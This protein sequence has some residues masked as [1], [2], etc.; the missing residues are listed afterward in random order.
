MGGQGLTDLV[1]HGLAEARIELEFAVD[2]ARYRVA[3][4][5]SRRG[6]SSATFERADGED[7]LSDVEGSGVKVVTRRIEELLRLDFDAFTRAVVL[8]QGE[9]QRFLRG[10][11]DE[12]REVLTDLLGLHHYEVMGRRARARATELEVS[13]A[14]TQKILEE[15]YA[16]ATPERLDEAKTK[17]KAAAR[18]A[19]ALAKAVATATQLDAKVTSLR[20]GRQ[21]LELHKTGTE[22]IRSALEGNRDACRQAREREDELS[23][24]ARNAQ[25]GCNETKVQ[26]DAAQAALDR[27][28]KRYGSLEEL[29]RAEGSLQIVI[30]GQGDLAERERRLEKLASEL[31]TLKATVKAAQTKARE[32]QGLLEATKAR[33][34]E[35]EKG[36][37]DAN[38]AASE[39]VRRLGKAEE[40]SAELKE[41]VDETSS[42]AQRAKE[43]T[44]AKQEAQDAMRAEED[45]YRQLADQELASALAQHLR[46]GDPCP[47]CHRVLEAAP[48]VDAH[49]AEALAAG[50]ERRNRARKNL[51][52]ANE[53]YAKAQAA[54]TNAE[55][56][57]KRAQNALDGALDGTRNI[58]VL[59]SQA[60]RAQTL[61]ERR[62][63]ELTAARKKVEA[64]I[65]AESDA[66]VKAEN[67]VRTMADKTSADVEMTSDC[68]E[69][70]KRIESAAKTVRTQ[71]KGT[72]PPDAADQ[73]VKKR[74]AVA[75]A[76][77]EAKKAQ[78]AAAG[79]QTQL[80]QATQAL[81]DLHQSV[82]RLDAEIASLRARC[83]GAHRTMT[84][85]LKA[86][87]FTGK[88]AP[89]PRAV[90]PRETHLA[91]LGGWCDGVDSIL[92]AADGSCEN[93]LRGLDEELARLASS[94]E[95]EVGER[96]SPAQA[97]KRAEVDAREAKIRWEEAVQ[98]A[99]QRLEQRGQ[100]AQSIA[101]K[102]SEIQVLKSLAAELRADRFIQFIIQQTLDLLAV[103]ASDELMRISAD[104][105]SLVSREGEFYVIDH[106]NADEQR[107]VKTL[108]GGETF[109]AS[110]SLALALS[111][112]VGELATDGLGAKL[113]AVFIDEGFGTLDPE[114]LED[115]IDALERLRESHFMIGVITHLPGLAERIRHGIRVEKNAN[116]S[117]VISA[118]A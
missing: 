3:R 53:D 81:A 57:L 72:I 48:D 113:E 104:R 76:G 102:Q 50:E 42:C 10:D 12:R 105:Y 100:L 6:S 101:G 93:A 106:V 86:V 108:S 47:V 52:T 8:P 23:S 20:N 69:L 15:Q 7:W 58:D 19:A 114:T 85:A 61:A 95:I 40:A 91:E 45:G 17:H 37:K 56:R 43:K 68:K 34:E 28:I 11:R 39:D 77:E 103:R 27:L 24:A 83:A 33:S 109:L 98:Q 26:V 21:A 117:T 79:A 65:Q 54:N 87:G 75:E 80:Q 1:S 35:A 41:A 118:P 14:T 94:H 116:S 73:L 63:T 46:A 36:S 99:E 9:F 59:R 92:V 82:S 66:R 60:T 90:A 13:V 5:L 4:R 25:K 51:E 29:V 97:L 49:I 110:L 70:H 32:R 111:Q 67:L 16:D 44:E 84:E 64:A 96:S 89:M 18:R 38:E 88:V 107:S 31:T 78:L 2:D 74:Q 71:F 115:V 55:K 30:Q 22:E 112:Q 62:A